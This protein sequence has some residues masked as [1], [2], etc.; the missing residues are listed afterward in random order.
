MEFTQNQYIP[1]TLLPGGLVIC[2]GKRKFEE[3][4]CTTTTMSIIKIA[5]MW[6]V[7]M[8]IGATRHFNHMYNVTETFPSP[9]QHIHSN[10]LPF[11]LSSKFLSLVPTQLQTPC[12]V[13]PI[14]S[15]GASH[16][17]HTPVMQKFQIS[18]TP[19]IPALVPLLVTWLEGTSP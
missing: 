16:L 10:K 12:Q 3:R 6:T 2:Q 19:S 5:F 14:Y 1:D 9:H 11:T 17:A 18:P 8:K 4:S 15:Q 13:F 7:T